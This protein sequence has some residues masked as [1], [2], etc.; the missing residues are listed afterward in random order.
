MFCQLP[1]QDSLKLDGILLLNITHQY[2]LS[3]HV[4]KV[5]KLKRLY[6]GNLNQRLQC[7]NFHKGLKGRSLRK[8]LRW[9]S[10][11]FVFFFVFFFFSVI[12]FFLSLSCFFVTVIKC[13]KIHKSV[14]LGCFLQVSLS[15]NWSGQ[16]SKVTLSLTVAT[17]S[18]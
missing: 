6:R 2:Q 15:F 16:V 11:V 10:I 8:F 7:Q 17:L 18:S 4:G 3:S 9:F 5:W 12:I 14:V 1:P 13:L